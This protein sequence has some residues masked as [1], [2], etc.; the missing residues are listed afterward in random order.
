MIEGEKCVDR[1]VIGSKQLS[2]ASR[3]RSV[4]KK[5]NILKIASEQSYCHCTIKAML[6]IILLCY[7]Q[8]LRVN[9]T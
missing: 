5:E 2:Q 4:V 8:L 1:V 6:V 9:P 3:A 7:S